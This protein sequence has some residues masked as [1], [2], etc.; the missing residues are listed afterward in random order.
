[1]EP[2][3]SS[4]ASLGSL[5]GTFDGGNFGSASA[6]LSSFIFDADN[7]AP[8]E[9]PL[10]PTIAISSPSKAIGGKESMGSVDLFQLSG[11]DWS[12]CATIDADA[13]DDAYQRFGARLFSLGDADGN[14]ANDELAVSTAMWNGGVVRIYG[15]NDGLL[16]KSLKVGSDDSFSRMGY[17]VSM[18]GD[19]N[20]DAK[21][22]LAISAPAARINGQ[23]SAGIVRI[24]NWNDIDDDDSNSDGDADSPPFLTIVGKPEN[25][26]MTGAAVIPILA[27]PNDVHSKALGLIMSRPARKIK[28]EW[29][30]GSI[31]TYSELRLA[32][33]LPQRLA[34]LSSNAQLGYTMEAVPD[35]D[36][37]G[38]NDVIFGQ[39]GSRCNGKP[40]GAVSLF[41]VLDKKFSF[42]ICSDYS[43]SSMGKELRY[44]PRSNTLAF[45][46]KGSLFF[47]SI[48][49]FLR[50]FDI[51]NSTH[52]PSTRTSSEMGWSSSWISQPTQGQNQSTDEILSTDPERWNTSQ[53]QGYVARLSYDWSQSLLCSYRSG[54]DGAKMGY[55]AEFIGDIGGDGAEDMA[56][57]A[58]MLPAGSS[59]G[60]V[61]LVDGSK[62]IGACRDGDP[63][64]LSESSA[65][66]LKKIPADDP[67]IVSAL[68]APALPG[69][70][71][72]VLPL[73]DLDGIG[74]GKQFLFVANTNMHHGTSGVI[75]QFLI[76]KLDDS[77]D[78][79]VVKHE[80]GLAG[81]M[82]G[83][84]A[85]KL[86]DIDG[87]GISELAVSYP[88]GIG[89]LGYTG[90]VI[91]Y[92]GAK[93]LT[94]DLDDDIIQKL[95]NPDS[96]PSHF[97]KAV[98]YSDITGDGISDFVVTASGYDSDSYQDAGAV[99]IYQVEPIVE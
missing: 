72:L 16:L 82:L 48:W 87:D 29:Q 97:G 27:N 37:D 33:T 52:F 57:G 61:L 56:F 40:W 41:T 47:S 1:M 69:F 44:L 62:D 36:N 43:D 38:V 35:I 46:K 25:Y 99:Y 93:L 30:V 84:T 92:S 28:G 19:F 13:S 76:L 98:M 60:A 26:A 81:G 88:G 58:P 77:L 54:F 85:I 21:A 65:L 91:I 4:L 32:P 34:G 71:A 9:C 73:G 86:A 59:Q 79:A 96:N 7:A 3:Q 42:N 6:F 39:I 11:E 66:I 89:R 53:N 90:Q 50:N 64:T 22:D 17:S 5:H 74:D 70:G 12:H 67:A 23:W 45:A 14:L 51:T 18:M 15:G 94:P 20:D 31:A 80:T 55:S 10:G 83:G 68:G 75:P 95:Y 24:Y 8:A 78:V 49:D 63:L 2:Q